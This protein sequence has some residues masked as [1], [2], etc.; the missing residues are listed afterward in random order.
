MSL[1]SGKKGASWLLQEQQIVNFLDH[2][3]IENGTWTY[4]NIEQ[5]WGTGGV[6]TL[7]F[8]SI[9]VFIF[10]LALF[11]AIVYKFFK[12]HALS[13]KQVIGYGKL[14]KTISLII[15]QMFNQSIM[16]SVPLTMA[17]YQML[18]ISIYT[19]VRQKILTL[20][21]FE[22]LVLPEAEYFLMNFFNLY[23]SFILY[24]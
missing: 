5:S 7:Y 17:S 20:R 16:V 2:V 4:E 3:C 18:S 19:K 12:C 8:F 15:W 1:K 22:I 6:I 14:L 11:L 9:F 23:E 24:K 21:L 13:R 10:N